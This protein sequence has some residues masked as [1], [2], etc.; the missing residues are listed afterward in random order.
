MMEH[1]R[2]LFSAENAR[3]QQTTPF[4]DF[5]LWNVTLEK[6]FKIAKFQII[7]RFCF[8]K[9][10]L[11]T[12]L[13]SLVNE[14]RT[15]YLFLTESI[16]EQHQGSAF[17]I[18]AIMSGLHGYPPL[19]VSSTH[20]INLLFQQNWEQC[21]PKRWAWSIK[22]SFP[23]SY[24]KRLKS[25]LFESEKHVFAKKKH[26]TFKKFHNVNIHFL[27]NGIDRQSAL[28]PFLSW[29]SAPET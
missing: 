23:S 3:N 15:I 9:P 28:S 10:H 20:Y 12:N 29:P 19:L 2:F 4:F 24:A 5:F 17:K 7:I 26:S 14:I 13:S 18:Y 8:D 1:F 11:E 6:S 16:F 22:T 25:T 21:M 27:L